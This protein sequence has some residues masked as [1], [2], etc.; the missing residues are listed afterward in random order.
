VARA[1]Q[2]PGTRFEVRELDDGGLVIWDAHLGQRHEQPG[3]PDSHWWPAGARTQ[4]QA[5]V[6]RQ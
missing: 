5:W 2:V 1:E 4:A 3:L 6:D